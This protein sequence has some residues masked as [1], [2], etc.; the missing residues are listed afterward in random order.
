MAD[1]GRKTRSTSNTSSDIVLP[2]HVTW[3]SSGRCRFLYPAYILPHEAML[4]SKVKVPRPRRSRPVVTYLPIT[5]FL[6]FLATSL[7]CL[8]AI[9]NTENS[10]ARAQ[11]PYVVPNS[12]QSERSSTVV[13]IPA[14]SGDRRRLPVFT[15]DQPGVAP[16]PGRRGRF[17]WPDQVNIG[18][19]LPQVTNLLSLYRPLYGM[20]YNLPAIQC[21]VDELTFN[22]S[23]VPVGVKVKVTTPSR[24]L[25][26]YTHAPME[27][28]DMTYDGTANVLFGPYNV[29]PAAQINRY[30]VRWNVPVLT[31]S[32]MMFPPNNMFPLTT[33]LQSSYTKLGLAVYSMLRHFR[34]K[35]VGLIYEH[36]MEMAREQQFLY[37]LRPLF[38]LIARGLTYEP[39]YDKIVGAQ[40]DMEKVLTTVQ[41]GSRSEYP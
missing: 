14:G 25:I 40:S 8:P 16:L 38:S 24:P 2:E 5:H 32:G 20:E 4:E 39:P 34:Y 37:M 26:F 31:T 15:I 35:V 7:V 23:T 28:F 3:A 18:V 13:D 11:S 41:Q 29:W 6:I 30:A 21:A 17:L 9:F 10:F 33:R 19:L 22:S 27:A 12:N 36:V 1:E